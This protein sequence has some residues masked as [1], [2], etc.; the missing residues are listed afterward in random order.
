MADYKAN[1]APII[2]D[3]FY[4]T[5][6]YGIY[7]SGIL[8]VGLDIATPSG[9]PLYSMVNGSVID[10]GFTN[11]R[12]YYIIMKDSSSG[13][14]FLYQHLRE[15]TPLNLGDSVEIGQYVGFEGASGQVTGIHLHIEEQDLSSGRNWNFAQDLQYY[16]NPCDYMGF[17][18]IEGISVIYNGTPIPPT[19]T[20]TNR[21]KTKFK[22]VLYA[23]KIRNRNKF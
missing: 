7:R 19:P 1:I 22:W 6:E 5:S 13:I 8:H 2:N 12:G 17:P 23:R 9:S 20:P 14:A 18:N 11:A 10:K 21:Q 15:E 3:T 16:K 4:V